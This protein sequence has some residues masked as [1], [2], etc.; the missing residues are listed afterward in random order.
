MAG[1]RNISGGSS[2][3][4]SVNGRSGFDLESHIAIRGEARERAALL[5][6]RVQALRD[7]FESTRGYRRVLGELRKWKD[8][9]NQAAKV[10]TTETMVLLTGASGTG[11]PV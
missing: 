7:E 1:I 2:I 5:E 4:F 3:V 10:A 11:R 8:V 9:L 6:E